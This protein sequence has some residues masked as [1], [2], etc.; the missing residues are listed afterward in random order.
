[1]S[2]SSVLRLVVLFDGRGRVNIGKAGKSDRGAI[3]AHCV[4]ILHIEFFA[5]L[6][7]VEARKR[8]ILIESTN[9]TLL[10]SRLRLR[11]LG[12]VSIRLFHLISLVII[13]SLHATRTFFIVANIIEVPSSSWSFLLFL[14]RRFIFLLFLF[15]LLLLDVASASAISGTDAVEPVSAGSGLIS[16][17]I[18]L[19][20]GGEALAS[21]LHVLILLEVLVGHGIS[22]SRTVREGRRR[23]FFLHLEFLAGTLLGPCETFDAFVIDDHALRLLV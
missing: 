2:F 21:G 22:V 3:N 10:H 19:D 14:L 12:S 9:N 13:P 4:D 6:L 16:V 5:V 1:M 8:V 20:G 23:I 15:L 18:D 17:V 7:S 11:L